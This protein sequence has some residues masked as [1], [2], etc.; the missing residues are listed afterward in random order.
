MKKSKLKSLVKAERKTAQ[1]DIKTGLVTA[2]TE[3]TASF[4]KGSKKL[5]K[6]IEQIAKQLSK[7]LDKDIKIDKEAIKIDK[8]ALK[9]AK[10]EAKAVAILKNTKPA[11]EDVT[12][13]VS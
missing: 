13:G 12:A 10:E 7:L 4:G 6:Q 2:I 11:K 5:N 9:P 3:A 8:E 1:K